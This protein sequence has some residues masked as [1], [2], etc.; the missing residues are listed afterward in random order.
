MK[1]TFLALLSE[2]DQRVVPA[3]TKGHIGC[4]EA[5]RGAVDS[6]ARTGPAVWSTQ[7]GADALA[8]DLFEHLAH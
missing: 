3:V 7:R 8:A 1:G 6:R 4:L 5:L 2:L